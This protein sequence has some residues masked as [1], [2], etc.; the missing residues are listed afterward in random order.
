MLASFVKKIVTYKFSYL[1]IH[2]KKVMGLTSTTP[3][4]NCSNLWKIY[5]TK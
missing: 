5:L 2:K 4:K 1:W 3:K